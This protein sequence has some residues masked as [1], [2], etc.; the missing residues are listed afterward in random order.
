MVIDTEPE[1]LDLEK[2][3]WKEIWDATEEAMKK[4]SYLQHKLYQ[5]AQWKGWIK[6]PEEKKSCPLKENKDKF[7]TSDEAEKAHYGRCGPECG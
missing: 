5:Y 7:V 1:D 4:L 2:M 6:K 3:F